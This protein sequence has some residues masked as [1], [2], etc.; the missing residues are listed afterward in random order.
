MRREKE[1]CFN[2]NEKFTRGHKCASSLF[3][4]VADENEESLETSLVTLNL[5]PLEPIE[6]L[7]STQ[8][9]LHVLSG[10]IAPE[11]LRVVGLISNQGVSILIDGDNTHNFI[12][13]H[14]VLALGL[15]TK[16]I[17]PLHVPVENGDE[18]ECHQLCNDVVVQIQGHSF[19][20]DFHFLSLCGA[21]VVLGVQRLKS[22][23]PILT[24]YNPNHEIHPWQ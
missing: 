23:G 22:L 10:H 12:Q 2:C 7:S 3:L 1:V 9:S 16:T 6:N 13:H 11:T 5:V 14:V 21:N 17:H 20:V 4:V 8:I 19:P 18:L 24:H 15:Q